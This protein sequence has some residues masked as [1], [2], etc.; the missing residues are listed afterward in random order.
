ME[1]TSLLSPTDAIREMSDL[2]GVTAISVRRLTRLL[3]EDGRGLWPEFGQGIRGSV[4]LPHLI[5]LWMAH[6][7]CAGQAS[8]GPQAAYEF[9][10]LRLVGHV[11]H[12]S[13]TAVHA[14]E[15]VVSIATEQREASALWFPRRDGECFLADLLC[16]I[17]R[18]LIR[19]QHVEVNRRRSTLLPPYSCVV[20]RITFRSLG[21]PI[22]AEVSWP[23]P[24]TTRDH[25]TK[26]FKISSGLGPEPDSNLGLRN[27]L[28]RLQLVIGPDELLAF[29]LLAPKTKDVNLLHLS[30]TPPTCNDDALRSGTA[31]DASPLEGHSMAAMDQ[32]GQKISDDVDALHCGRES[33]K[34]ARL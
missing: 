3:R 33:K 4:T 25:E 8:D 11:T 14:E 27:K 1:L 20:I 10:Q 2:L 32:P 23:G 15:S 30:P 29:N 31:A 16:A 5:N 17:L 6:V 34:S 28:G 21:R 24:F 7:L 9:N 12:Q 18:S 19:D 26:L 22:S 13:T